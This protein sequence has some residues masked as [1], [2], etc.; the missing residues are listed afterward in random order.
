MPEHHSTLATSVG[1]STPCHAS[2]H[3]HTHTNTR[4]EPW[5]TRPRTAPGPAPGPPARRWRGRP[6]IAA[7]HSRRREA[8]SRIDEPAGQASRHTRCVR[9]GGSSRTAGC[10]HGEGGRGP[11]LGRPPSPPSPTRRVAR[12]RPASP[13][14]APA[15]RRRPLSL[16]SS[17]RGAP[18]SPIGTHGCTP[19]VPHSIDVVSY[20]PV[21]CCPEGPAWD[22]ASGPYRLTSHHHRGPSDTSRQRRTRRP[23]LD[24]LNVS[25]DNEIVDADSR[26]P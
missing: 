25:A 4:S 22:G 17:T 12:R 20:C 7:R 16:H 18:P 10:R 19:R 9:I 8:S 15:Y 6:G 21:T 2:S 24:R 23:V 1:I 26:A 3:T 11:R 5:P 13:G 14:I